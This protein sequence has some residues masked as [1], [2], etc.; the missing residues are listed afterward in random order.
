MQYDI[1]AMARIGRRPILFYLL[2][3]FLLGAA[4]ASN[5]TDLRQFCQGQVQPEQNDMRRL[6]HAVHNERG[7]YVP[8]GSASHCFFIAKLTPIVGN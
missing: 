6:H 1:I 8:L 4:G 2:A 7:L 3:A 5:A